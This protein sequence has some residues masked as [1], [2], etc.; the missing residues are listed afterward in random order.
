MSSKHD[1]LGLASN[2]KVLKVLSSYSAGNEIVHLSDKIEKIN[3]KMKVQQRVIMITSRAIYNLDPKNVGACKRRIGLEMVRMITASSK[4][5]QFVIHVPSEYDYFFNSSVKDEVVD[6]VRKNYRNVTG[7]E[8]KV[9][10]ID[11]PSLKEVVMSK[12]SKKT[13]DDVLGNIQR[14]KGKGMSKLPSLDEE[15][16]GTLGGGSETLISERGG[17]ISIDDFDILKVLGKGSFG[18]VMLVRH[19]QSAQIYALKVLSKELI[20]AR[21]QVEHTKSERNVLQSIQH[22]YMVR[23]RFAFQTPQKLYM[24]MDYLNGGELFFHLKNEGR[25][26][27]DRTRVYVAEIAAALGH[28]HANNIIY[29]DLK[30]ENI[31][32]DKEGHIAITDFGLAKEAK[33]KDETTNTFCGTPEYLAPEIL[34]NKEGHIA[35]TDFGLAKEAK[36]KDETTNTFCGTP[37][38]LAPEILKSTGHG[39]AVDWWSLGTL[40]FEMLVGLPPFY[41]QNLNE[42]YA[43]ILEADVHYPKFISP[44]AKGLLQ[45]FLERDPEKRLGGGESDFDEIKRHPFFAPLDWDA[46]MKKEVPAPFKPDIKGELDISNFDEEF[47]SE[48]P[49]DSYLDDTGLSGATAKFEGFTFVDNSVLNR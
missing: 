27:E 35:I 9:E 42:M 2:A 36:F 26:D 40:M 31:L 5:G 44:D 4:T 49:V 3:R 29:R 12:D 19:K 21:K 6:V 18:K 24:V 47:T 22:P 14:A 1:K 23:L 43:N 30:P 20:A 37:E 7:R 46:L 28:L 11:N 16:S 48:D 41:S 13:F 34:K 8:L 38:Y 17:Q 39:R 33:F 10:V 45:G 25:F 32:L 15:G